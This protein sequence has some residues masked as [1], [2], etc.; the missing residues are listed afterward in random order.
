MRGWT[1]SSIQS[2]IDKPIKTAVAKETRFDTV[3]GG[4]LNDPATGYIAKD[5]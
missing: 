1:E 5:V 4:R 3:S 2:V